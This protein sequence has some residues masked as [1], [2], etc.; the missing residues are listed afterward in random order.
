MNI[1]LDSLIQ[2]AMNKVKANKENDICHYLPADGEGYLHHFTM[3]KM[4]SED[5][6]HLANLISQ[7]ILQ[8]DQPQSIT[9]KPR[10]ARGSKRRGVLPLSKQEVELMLDM[11]RRAGHKDI[12]RKL[13]PRK[14]LKSAK[15]E[16]IASIRQGKVEHELWHTFAELTAAA[17]PTPASI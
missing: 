10:A 16:L 9:P 11:A 13:I 8:P 4:K 15:R 14:D 3:R 17:I 1:Q 6:Q 12:V 7:F 2:D 5:P